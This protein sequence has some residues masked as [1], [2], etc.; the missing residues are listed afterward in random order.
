M[1]SINSAFHVARTGLQ[2]TEAMLQVKA[3]NIAGQGVLSF[4]KEGLIGTDRS[5]I[6]RVRPGTQTS[7]GTINPNGYQVGTGVQAA[8]IYRSFA[9]GEVIQTGRYLDVMIDGEGFLPVTMPDGTT[10][11]SRIGI[12]QTD[13]NNNLVMPK[14][15]YLIAPAITLPANTTGVMINE[16]GQVYAEI[17]NVQQLVGQLELATFFNPSGL[18]ALGDGMYMETNASGTADRGIPGTNRRGRIMQGA[19]E[20]SNVNAMEETTDLIKIEKIYE[21]LTKVL[22]TGDA[23]YEAGN[24][25]GR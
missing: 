10:A 13:G 25:V 1:T 12:L 8:G 20:G 7:A 22:K 9:Q 11:Y 16:S 5:Y 23:M 6:D 3:T 24:R 18:K 21:L 14:T 2:L 17:A 15:G 4:K 19:H